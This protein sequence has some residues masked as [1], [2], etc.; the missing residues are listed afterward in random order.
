MYVNTGPHY[1][2]TYSFTKPM[3]GVQTYMGTWIVFPAGKDGKRSKMEMHLSWEPDDA[4]ANDSFESV[5]VD[6]LQNACLAAPDKN[7]E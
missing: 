4:E 3:V 2:F 7:E 1:L 5:I 6:L